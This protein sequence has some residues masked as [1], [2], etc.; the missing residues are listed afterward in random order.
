M[1][2]AGFALAAPAVAESLRRVRPERDE[3]TIGISE[4]PKSAGLVVRVLAAD[5]AALKR[6]MYRAWCAARVALKGAPPVERRK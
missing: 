6:A 1:I 4:L 5:G 2:V 3:A